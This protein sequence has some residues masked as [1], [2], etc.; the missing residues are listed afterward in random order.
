MRKFWINFSGYCMVEAPNKEQAEEQFDKNFHLDIT[1]PIYHESYKIENI[2]E[3]S[4][5]DEEEVMNTIKDLAKY[6][7]SLL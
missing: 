6:L 1:N 3:V 4:E 5:K 2:E 7:E